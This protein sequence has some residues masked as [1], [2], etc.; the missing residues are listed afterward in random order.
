[1][2][3]FRAGLITL[4]LR[5]TSHLPL[6]LARRLG[7]LAA[8]LYWPLGG[9]SR[10]VTERNIELAFP[11]LS[12]GQR[13]RLARR[14]LLATG[15]LIGEMGHIWLKP[16]DYV[17]SLCLDVRGASLVTDA[18]AAGRGVICL[19]PHLGNWEVVGLQLPSLGPA[20]ALFEPPN[21]AALGPIMQRARERSGC[22][23]VP[24]DTRGLGQLL[25][26]VKRG[27]IS[28]ILPDQAPAELSAGANAPF[29]GIPCFTPTLA[30]NML[31]RTGALA[32]FTFAE[33]VTGGFI[34]HFLPAEDAIYSKDSAEALAAMN[35]GVEMCV[36]MAPE[37]YQW[38]YKRFRVRPRSGPGVYDDL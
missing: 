19:G 38:E 22:T 3:G 32:V 28:G 14:S 6:S 35:R 8:S 13:R 34:L 7:R 15:E 20:V 17:S 16:H 29:M 9:R 24:T 37:Q 18:L 27:Q 30:C 10:R 12:P 2:D 1:M 33:R 21:L 31:R 11:D 25:R 36:R 5:L 26:S 4:M 23:L